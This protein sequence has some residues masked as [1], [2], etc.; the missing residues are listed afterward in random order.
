MN[1]RV[2][3]YL[4]L[5]VLILALSLRLVGL[6][7]GMSTDE[8]IELERT[9]RGGLGDVV[10]NFMGDAH[11]PLYFLGLHLW[12]RI[13]SD[14]AFLRLPSVLMGVGTVL[15]IML[16]LKRYSKLASIIAGVLV[17][18]APMF[19]AYSQEIREYSLFLLAISLT[20][21]LASRLADKPDRPSKYLGLGLS[22]TLAIASHLLAVFMLLP[23]CAFLFTIPG[24]RRNIR[25]R[26]L[27]PAIAIPAVVFL[28]LD[29]FY[30]RPAVNPMFQGLHKSQWWLPPI[31][32]WMV[33][34]TVNH[35]F[36][37]YFLPWSWEQSKTILLLVLP[38][39]A[40]ALDFGIWRRSF[41]FLIAALIYWLEIIGYSVLLTPLFL[42]RFLLAGLIP[43]FGFLALQI[44]SIERKTMRVES[45]AMC[46][47]ACLIFAASWTTR[48]ASKP[49]EPW[50]Q[51]SQYLAS[52][53]TG[54][55]ILM[56]Y[57]YDYS[58]LV[59][60][61]CPNLQPSSVLKPGPTSE[62]QEFARSLSSGIDSIS[63][64]RTL[65]SMFL[66]VR[67]DSLVAQARATLQA[68]LSV[69]KHRISRD[70]TLTVLSFS[71]GPDIE[72]LTTAMTSVLGQPSW[73]RNLGSFTA[74]QFVLHDSLSP[75]TG[76][77]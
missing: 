39:F 55:G 23:V 77:P 15:V 8:G 43:L 65:S 71:C 67:Y 24:V 10:V 3:R 34:N 26:H 56:T 13:D 58:F 40:V 1:E 64:G 31:S 49:V 12:S 41:P 14:E 36:G 25:W 57:P 9:L 18:T 32:H 44:A 5:G 30:L 47:V 7:K 54:N 42:D 53:W 35:L 59:R 17:A 68:G 27:I 45:M 22:L 20:F 4:A 69:L 11:P 76:S 16:W 2:Y 38:W 46:G 50:K 66:V 62:K 51:V 63:K 73:A 70:G 33:E 6:N 37:L 74:W 19:L 72:S 48:W 60:Y 21:F 75:S 52:Q 29:F 61:Y 28:V